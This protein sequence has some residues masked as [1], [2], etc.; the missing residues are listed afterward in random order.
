[1]Q[2]ERGNAEQLEGPH[3]SSAYLHSAGCKRV[4]S[5]RWGKHRGQANTQHGDQ[6]TGVTAAGRGPW[7]E[8]LLHPTA[9]HASL[10]QT[11]ETIF[12]PLTFPNQFH[13]SWIADTTL[14]NRV[15][16]SKVRGFPSCHQAWDERSSPKH[17]CFSKAAEL[18]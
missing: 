10:H 14:S 3:L 8:G 11:P 12:P 4:I 1:M 17:S 15:I 9:A 18:V 2:Q 6:N 16:T 13:P 5:P 7:S